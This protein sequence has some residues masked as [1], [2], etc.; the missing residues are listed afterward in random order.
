M[1]IILSDKKNKEIMLS[2]HPKYVEAIFSGEKKFEFRKTKF[3]DDVK[4]VIIYST[5]PIKKV[6]GEFIVD[7][8]I[9]QEPKNLWEL[10]KEHSG[11]SKEDFFKYYEKKKTGFAL[12]IGELKR[13]EKSKDLSE[14]GMKTA[15]QS[16]AYIKI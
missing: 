16:F 1:E 15:P 14:Y 6:V 11:I 3:K 2:I 13:Y 12:K 4:K 9:E 5:N 7:M 8:I 10:Y